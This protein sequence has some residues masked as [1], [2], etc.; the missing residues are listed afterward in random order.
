[1]SFSCNFLI[2]LVVL[3]CTGTLTAQESL[4]QKEVAS[5]ATTA[6]PAAWVYVQTSKGVNVYDAAASGQLTLVK[7]SP[8]ADTGAMEGHNGKYLLVVG[9]DYLHS[10][11]IGTNG[12]VGAQVSEI[13]TQSYSGS[14]CGNTDSAGAILDHTGSFFYVQL[15]GASYNGGED[16]TCAAWQT[17]KIGSNGEFTFL[18][19]NEL[20]Y[21]FDSTALSST[22]PTFSSNDNFTYGEYFTAF[23]PVYAAFQRDSTGVLEENPNFT[24]NYPTPN[25]AGS[26]NNYFP[27]ATVADPNGHLAIAMVQSFSSLYP[28]PALQLASFTIN[29]KGAI[30]T[31]NTWADMPTLPWNPDYF[32]GMNMSPAGNLLAVSG[33]T[34][35]EIFHFNGAASITSYSSLL[36]PGVGVN[37]VAWDKSNHLYALSYA[38]G[39]YVFTVTPTS[40]SEVSGSPYKITSPIPGNGLKDMIVVPK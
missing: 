10:Y 32:T 36:L 12:A 37:E 7:G 39:L 35:L 8:F 19:A 40:I 9:T 2:C 3:V 20:G 38:K 30:A 5:A 23:A 27:Q 15:T 31:T 33:S 26:D 29:S 13:N 17:Y 34:G 6:S 25:P 16:T 21:G 11:A 14:E 28:L 22:V 1:V 24:Y 18:G 4:T